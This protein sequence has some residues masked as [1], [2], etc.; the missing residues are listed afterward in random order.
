MIYNSMVLFMAYSVIAHPCLLNVSVP[1]PLSLFFLYKLHFVGDTEKLF[2]LTIF[3]S[4]W[5]FLYTP[6]KHKP[7]LYSLSLT[8]FT[9]HDTLESHP[10]CSQLQD[11]VF[12]QPVMYPGYSFCIHP[13]APHLDCIWKVLFPWQVSH[14]WVGRMKMSPSWPEPFH[15]P[16]SACSS[17]PH[18]PNMPDTAQ[19]KEE[20]DT[21]EFL[22]ARSNFST[23]Q[24]AS[25]RVPPR[26]QNMYRVHVRTMNLC[27]EVPGSR[28]RCRGTWT[29][30]LLLL[31]T[32]VFL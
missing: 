19:G 3:H 20:S 10:H 22:P 26:G 28:K 15:V 24:A 7:T 25:G 14:S 30:T 16:C 9:P 8:H 32:L 12:F 31:S 23:A 17:T 1:P 2:T 11:S 29:S 4:L 13:P 21:P 18:H 5:V 6:H 27:T